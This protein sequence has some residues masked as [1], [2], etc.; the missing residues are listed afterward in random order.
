[1]P[2]AF[3][4]AQLMHLLPLV[5]NKKSETIFINPLEFKIFFLKF[6]QAYYFLYLD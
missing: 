4:L 3:S 1:M 6:L 2:Q 5:Q